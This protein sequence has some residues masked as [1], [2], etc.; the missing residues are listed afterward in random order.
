MR[1]RW[2]I[3][4]S[5]LVV[6]LA[7]GCEK[8]QPAA[9]PGIVMPTMTTICSNRR[10]G[11]VIEVRHSTLYTSARVRWCQYGFP[12]GREYPDDHPCYLKA[13]IGRRKPIEC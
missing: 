7:M 5:G 12:D 9:Q 4:A 10:D 2:M 3:A 13:T 8:D 1:N 6:L 11:T